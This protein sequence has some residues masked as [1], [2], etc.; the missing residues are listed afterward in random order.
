MCD[1]SLRYRHHTSATLAAVGG[2]SDG[3][4][5]L[6]WVPAELEQ[7]AIRSS[8][9]LRPLPLPR[10]A[11]QQPRPD[12]HQSESATRLSTRHRLRGTGAHAP[13]SPDTHPGPAGHDPAPRASSDAVY[14]TTFTA[15]S[16]VAVQLR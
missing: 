15:A 11:T 16:E 5:A 10:D 12:R 3:Y 9:E 8:G 6:P 1:A 4:A 14:Q 13:R 2:V 7:S